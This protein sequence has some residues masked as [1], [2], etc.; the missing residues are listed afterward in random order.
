MTAH[1]FRPRNPLTGQPVGVDWRCV[2]CDGVV[3]GDPDE[4]ICPPEC[5]ECGHHKVDCLCDEFEEDGS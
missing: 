1:A 5:H 4:H 3:V 2:F